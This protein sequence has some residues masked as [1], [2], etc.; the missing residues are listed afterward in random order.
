MVWTTSSMGSFVGST[1]NN[2]AEAMH[3]PPVITPAHCSYLLVKLHQC[4]I[5]EMCSDMKRFPTAEALKSALGYLFLTP[6]VCMLVGTMLSLEAWC[7][8]IERRAALGCVKKIVC[9]SRMQY[10]TITL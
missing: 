8:S 10:L 9:L 6:P 1:G 5:Y 7:G 3:R 4:Y 2:S